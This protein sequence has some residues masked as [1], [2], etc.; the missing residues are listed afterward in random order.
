MIETTQTKE[1]LPLCREIC[2]DPD[3]IVVNGDSKATL[4]RQRL[5]WKRILECPLRDRYTCRHVVPDEF[6]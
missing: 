5:E 4:N 6:K 2:V 1:P 3:L